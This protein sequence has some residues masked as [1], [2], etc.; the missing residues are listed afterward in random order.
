VTPT[1]LIKLSLK[2]T[3][4]LGQGQN[5]TQQQLTDALS[6]LNMMLGQWARKR[7]L[8][9]HLIDLQVIGT[10]AG[11]YALGPGGDFTISGDVRWDASGLTWD[12]NFRANRIESAYVRLNAGAAQQTDLP[13]GIIRAYED[14]AS[15]PVKNVMG[16]LPRVIFVDSGYP[17]ATIHVW[18]ALTSQ[19]ELHILL[20]NPLVRFSELNQDINLPD[21]Y[22]EAL[23]YNLARRLLSFY[24]KPIDPE[25]AV[26]A[27]TALQTVKGANLQIPQ[28]FLP[29][30]I[31]PVGGWGYN[32]YSDS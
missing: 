13:V 1:K 4:V 20:L 26:R 24:R 7:W 14:W 5:A 16:G 32:I 18:P 3:G 15:I 6:L 31:L 2:A 17:T 28:M 30:A 19:Y 29:S 22:Q 21:E 27:S 9:F 25:I 12:Q 11:S 10:G 23:M 8:V